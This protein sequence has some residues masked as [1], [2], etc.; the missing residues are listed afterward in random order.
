M[1]QATNILTTD[2]PWY[3]YALDNDALVWRGQDLDT[4]EEQ[5]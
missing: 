5:E 4:D 1:E 2:T 3:I